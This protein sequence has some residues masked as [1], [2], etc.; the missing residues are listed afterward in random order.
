M[1]IPD[2]MRIYLSLMLILALGAVFNL[3]SFAAPATA[4]GGV[5][6]EP[7]QESN[8]MLTVKS[9]S[10]NVNGNQAKT[11][12]T[13]LTGS[14]LSTSS[15]GDA[16]IDLGPTGR[17]ELGGSTTVTFTCVGGIIQVRSNCSKTYIKV[18]GGKVDVTQPKTESLL[19]GKDEKY[20]GATEAT[21]A[22]GTDWYVDCLGRKPVGLWI[23]PGLGGL[24]ALVGVG[25]AV[26]VG[27]E[28]GGPDDRNPTSP[29]R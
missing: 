13:I 17:L 18:H 7:P 14:I 24:L 12:A 29:T 8:G 27:I 28:L 10:I 6:N 9:G 22:V 1:K 21:A 4:P 15:D 19:S 3:S 20:D 2:G 25:T 23:G 5:D 26:V 11:G 16:I